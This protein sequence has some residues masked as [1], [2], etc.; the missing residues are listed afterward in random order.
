MLRSAVLIG[1]VL[2]AARAQAEETVIESGPERVSLLEL[3]TSEGCSSCPPAEA[4]V[5]RLK[6]SPDLWEK[7]VPLAFHVDYWDGLGWP[8]SLA[9]AAYTQRQRDYSRA[10]GKGGSVYTPGFVLDGAEWRGFFG[11]EELPPPAGESPGRLRASVAGDS[12][13]VVFSPAEAA[14]YRVHAALLGVGIETRVRA[15]ENRGRMLAHEFVVLGTVAGVLRR[16]SDGYTYRG[17]LPA[18]AVAPKKAG[19]LAVWVTQGD[20]MEPVQAA[21]GFLD[22]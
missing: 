16:G 6:E 19:A 15:G 9:S 2:W 1:L 7:I 11:R 10:W 3:Y 22:R 8:D 13:R 20:A 5:G 14:G 21:G 17:R 18:A 4:F 12:L